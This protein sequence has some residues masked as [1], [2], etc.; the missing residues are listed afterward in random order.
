MEE[1]EVVVVVEG[2]ALERHR[3]PMRE[4]LRED[5]GRISASAVGRKDETEV[6][7]HNANASGV[8]HWYRYVING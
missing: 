1:E 2:D 4:G 8:A 5:V 6:P 3:A 7:P